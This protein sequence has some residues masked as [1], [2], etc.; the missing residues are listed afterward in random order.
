VKEYTYLGIVQGIREDRACELEQRN[1]FS[2]GDVVEVM[3]PNGDNIQTEV[4]NL[5]DEEGN[6]MESCPHPQ[7]K[8]YVVFDQELEVGDLIRVKQ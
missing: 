3:K 4:L 6:Q 7:Q 2:I 8:I 1:K 5:T